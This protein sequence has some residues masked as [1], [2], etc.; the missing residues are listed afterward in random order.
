M[1]SST[2]PK[3]E[4]C[5]LT[6]VPHQEAAALQAGSLNPTVILGQIGHC[7]WGLVFSTTQGIGCV[8]GSWETPVPSPGG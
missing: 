5:I 4:I 7:R 3:L 1:A 2:C 6:C 8:P